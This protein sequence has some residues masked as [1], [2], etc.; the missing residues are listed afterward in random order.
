MTA[1]TVATKLAYIV[2]TGEKPVTRVAR[3]P[4]EERS[5][6][7]SYEDHD[8]LV[9][10]ARPRA[11][12]W[13]LD[14][15]G[16]ILRPQHTKVGDFYDPE[17]VKGAYH[18]ELER[19]LLEHT[20]AREVVVFD[21]TIRAESEETRQAKRVGRPVRRIHNDYTAW[22]APKRLREIIPDRA[23]KLSERRFAIVNVWR[24]I[25]GTVESMPLGLCEAGSIEEKDL[26]ATTRQAADRVGEIQHLAYNAGHRWYYFPKL[27]RDEALMFKC[28]D[29]AT[30]GRARYTAHCAFVDPTTPAGAAPRGS[31]EARAFVLF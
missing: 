11:A 24:S 22:S 10:N 14:K 27:T 6:S 29:S 25:A 17:E 4:G 19:L 18:P 3:N 7:G 12:E 8:A 13:S 1:D 5:N 30:D 21:T 20:G 26:I 28:Y 15:E 23:E 9:H 16:F 2:D 31:I